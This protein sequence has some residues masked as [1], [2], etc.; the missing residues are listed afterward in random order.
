MPKIS[1][2]SIKG[3][4]Y[5]GKW[6]EPGA[7]YEADGQGHARLMIAL[8]HATLT[9]PQ[10]TQG[11]QQPEAGAADHVD[12]WGTYA[13]RDQVAEQLPR[14]KRPPASKRAAAKSTGYRRRDQVAD[15]E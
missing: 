11:T 15:P 6:R 5:A 2:T 12:P 1:L 7:Q 4:R 3:H 8:K 14:G 13:R 9:P 10:A